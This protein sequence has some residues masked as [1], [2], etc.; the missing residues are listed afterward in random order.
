MQFQKSACTACEKTPPTLKSV[1]RLETS[2]IS[3]SCSWSNPSLYVTLTQ[4]LNFIKIFR[5]NTTLF[6]LSNSTVTLKF[7]QVNTDTDADTHIHTHTQCDEIIKISGNYWV[8]W[9]PNAETCQK[10]KKKRPLRPKA[11]TTKKKSKCSHNSHSS[12]KLKTML[13][14]YIHISHTKHTVLGIFNVCSN[15]T[16]S[17]TMDKNLK[18]NLQFMILTHVALKQGQGH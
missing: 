5:E 7:D 8:T 15:Y 4:S 12:A 11:T 6:H 17:T 1:W 13:V 9:H 3:L 14:S 18:I 16:C 2:I 10:K